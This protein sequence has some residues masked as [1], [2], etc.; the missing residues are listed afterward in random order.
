MLSSGDIFKETGVNRQTVHKWEEAGLL[1]PVHVSSSV[2]LYAPEVIERVR[3]IQKLSKETKTN[4]IKRILK[5][6]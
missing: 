4:L 6:M 1:V 5:G 3:L 2:K